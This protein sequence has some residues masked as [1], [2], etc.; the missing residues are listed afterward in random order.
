M[1]PRMPILSAALV[2]TAA[3]LAP[4]LVAQVPAAAQTQ[5]I[6]AQRGPVA[7]EPVVTGLDHPWGMDFLPDGRILVTERP[8]QMRIV[9]PQERTMSAPLDGVPEVFNRGQGGLLD[10]RVGPTYDQDGWIYFTYAEANQQGRASTAAARA[11]LDGMRL[12]DVDLVFRQIPKV[13]G[14]NHFGSRIAFT[15]DG[16]MF[17]T[18]GER[19]KF[20]P[21]QELTNH[22]GTVVRLWPD[23]SVPDD[24][25]FVNTEGALPEIWSFGHRNSQGAAV[26]PET[27]R[28]WMHEHG[29]RGGDEINV[30]E[31]GR[32]YG[33]PVVSWGQHYNGQPIPDP[34]THPEFADAIHYW[35]PVIAASGM[36]FYTGDL[37]PEWQGDLLVGGLVSEAV[38][39][40]ELN[41]QD[42]AGEERLP[43]GQRVR[44]VKQGPDGAVYVLTD[45]ADG[46]L[47]RLTPAQ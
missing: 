2:A 31:A 18:L 14:N 13:T 10:V 39:R 37:F 41:G 28:L 8:G 21:A 11:K 40:L 38:S 46:A 24:N 7:V 42:V 33:W 44:A 45:E 19:F 34:P 17:I 4:L 12:T 6:D 47:L 26:H 25:P 43:V 20:Q 30:P 3:A 5:Q 1:S 35:N 9:Y 16:Y 23:G 29:P 36:D 27:G 15:P 32:N 22:L